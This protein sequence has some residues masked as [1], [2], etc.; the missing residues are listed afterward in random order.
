MKS[1]KKVKKYFTEA[2][3][4]GRSEQLLQSRQDVNIMYQEWQPKSRVEV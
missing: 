1:I 2:L 3:E 4:H